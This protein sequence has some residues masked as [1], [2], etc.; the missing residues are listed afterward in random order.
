MRLTTALLLISVAFLAIG[1]SRDDEKTRPALERAQEELEASIETAE[2]RLAEANAEARK[3]L[4][5]AMERWDELRPEAER[6]IATLEDRVERL[7]N[8]S[9]T[10]KRLPPNTLER[11]RKGLDDMRQKLAEAQAAYERG[12]TGLA[13]ERPMLSS[14][15]ARPS[16]ICSWRGRTLRLRTPKSDSCPASDSVAHTIRMRV[17]RRARMPRRRT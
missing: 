6:A 1:C 5:A 11:V 16:R 8:D 17:P 13:V 10:L 12:D 9:E 3:A 15:K 14:R 2:T 4:A 7:V